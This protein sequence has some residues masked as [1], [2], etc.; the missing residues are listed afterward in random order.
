MIHVHGSAE[1]SDPGK[2]VW[3][4][5]ADREGFQAAHAEAG[6]GAV[7][8]AGQHVVVGLDLGDDLLQERALKEVDVVVDGDSVVP[9]VKAVADEAHVAVAERHDEDHGTGFALC[10]EGVEDEVWRGR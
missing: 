6:D 4:G 7:L 9:D 5:E 10:D 8:A 1:T 2:E 3:V